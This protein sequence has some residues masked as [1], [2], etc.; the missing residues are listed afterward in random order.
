MPLGGSFATLSVGVFEAAQMHTTLIMVHGFAGNGRDFDAVAGPLA[1]AGYRV[2][3]PDMPGRGRSVWFDNPAHYRFS[4]HGRALVALINRFADRPVILA[5]IGWGGVIIALTFTM[6]TLPMVKGVVLCGVPLSW[7][8]GEDE[9][10]VEAARDAGL[11]FSTQA[12]GIDH[13]LAGCRFRGADPGHAVN[14][15]KGRLI[16]DGEGWKPAFDPALVLG[17]EQAGNRVYDITQ[18][19]PAITAP[20]QVIS[21]RRD[22]YPAAGPEAMV[23]DSPS[24]FLFTRPDEQRMLMTALD[25]L[26]DAATPAQATSG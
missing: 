19:L 23:A 20:T 17:K 21:L 12:A 10:L 13:V 9:E 25:R 26:S 15:A 3:C 4:T 7:H 11:R 5:G 24:A 8:L 2:L 6:A 22:G 18:V 1:R 14:L 16:A